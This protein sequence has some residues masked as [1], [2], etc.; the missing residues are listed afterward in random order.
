M[1]KT[2]KIARPITTTTGSTARYDLSGQ[3]EVFSLYEVMELLSSARKSGVLRVVTPL[4]EGKCVINRGSLISASIMRLSDGEAVIEMLSNHSGIFFF[5]SSPSTDTKGEL[6]LT[7]LLMETVRLE[8]EF[9]RNASH[10]PDEATRLGLS[11][12]GIRVVTDDLSCG[13]PH[14]L[15]VIANKPKM[16]TPQL[17][18][19]IPLASIKIRLAVA[20]LSSSGILGEYNTQAI[21]L[22]GIMDS[23][24]QKLLFLG[25]GGSRILLATHPEDGPEEI[26]KMISTVAGDTKAPM[27][28][29]T[30]PHDGPGV[31]RLRPPT[32]GL[33]SITILPVHKRH[34]GTFLT[35]A[36]SAQLVAMGGV[37]RTEEGTAWLGLIPET[38]GLVAWE[39]E[40][41]GPDALRDALREYADSKM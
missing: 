17:M 40:A 15:E 29:I 24:H 23:W 28:E 5:T 25:G 39:Q 10:F 16:T 38:T 11:S 41:E 33:L 31:V 20:W 9:E 1:A 35:L 30:L 34:R 26:F 14:V 21:A 3:I 37:A 2:G 22:Q 8:D 6:D 4:A 32:G 36:A 18:A 27:P 7:S 12:R 19:A 13:A